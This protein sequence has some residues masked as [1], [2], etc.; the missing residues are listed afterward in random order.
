[1][2][3]VFKCTNVTME[4][5][6]VSIKLPNGK[7]YIPDIVAVHPK[8]YKMYI[9]VE[10]GNTPQNDF[11]DKCNKMLQVTKHFYFVSDIEENRKKVESEVSS[12]IVNVGGKEKVSGVVIYT[13]TMTKLKKGEWS[14]V[15]KF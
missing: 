1:M 11:N 6:K 14:N 9:E 15:L 3:D 4:R 12:W 2:I 7:T 10:L 8:K 13:T 5:Q